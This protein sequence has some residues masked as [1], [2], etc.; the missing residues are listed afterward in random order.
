MSTVLLRVSSSGRKN[1][2]PSV[3]S[4]IPK[5]SCTLSFQISLGQ[6]LASCPLRSQGINILGL[7]PTSKLGYCVDASMTTSNVTI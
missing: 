5:P 2:A 3:L 7:W 1:P 6:E 4:V